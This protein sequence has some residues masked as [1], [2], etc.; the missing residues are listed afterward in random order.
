MRS[1]CLQD[2]ERIRAALKRREELLRNKD[3]PRQSELYKSLGNS[4]GSVVI[5]NMTL[6]SKEVM[7]VTDPLKGPSDNLWLPPSNRIKKKLC[8][9]PPSPVEVTKAFCHQGILEIGE[10]F[11]AKVEEHCLERIKKAADEAADFE[12]FECERRLNFVLGCER[13]NH[14]REMANLEEAYRAALFAERNA[15][16]QEYIRGRTEYGAKYRCFCKEIEVKTQNNA[17]QTVQQA[18]G[19]SEGCISN[20]QTKRYEYQNRV[21]KCLWEDFKEHLR[22]QRHAMACSKVTEV[23]HVICAQKLDAQQRIEKVKKL[24]NEELNRIAGSNGYKLI[25]DKYISLLKSIKKFIQL[26]QSDDPE[27]K[28][29]LLEF[30]EEIEEE[31]CTIEFEENL[32]HCCANAKEAI[33]EKTSNDPRLRSP[34][35]I[36]IFS[37]AHGR[38]IFCSCQTTSEE[39]D[40]ELKNKYQVKNMKSKGE[41]YVDWSTIS[42]SDESSI[43]SVKSK[44]LSEDVPI[45]SDIGLAKKIAGMINIEHILIKA[46]DKVILSASGYVP[47]EVLQQK[48]FEY[49]TEQFKD[50]FNQ[51]AIMETIKQATDK[52]RQSFILGATDS[53]E[54]I[55]ARR[56]TKSG[57]AQSESTA[58]EGTV[59]A[60]STS[61]LYSSNSS[62]INRI[63]D[64]FPAGME[65]EEPEGE[66]EIDKSSEVVGRDILRLSEMH[67]PACL[68]SL[69][70][71]DIQQ[72]SNKDKINNRHF[73]ESMIKTPKYM[74]LSTSKVDSNWI[75]RKSP[76]KEW[77]ELLTQA[78]EKSKKEDEESI[79][80]E[81]PASITSLAD[82][83]LAKATIETFRRCIKED[84]H[85]IGKV[86]IR[87]L[88]DLLEKNEEVTRVLYKKPTMKQASTEN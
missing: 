50:T 45:T 12:R 47:I 64:D 42:E 62:C 79:E 26:S 38:H 39:E 14:H 78:Y 85:P 34:A 55:K 31:I 88:I 32:C 71:V 53:L 5:E 17:T 25:K 57:I 6:L 75:Y 76:E 69:E 43:S 2:V 87:S 82:P 74:Q 23:M 61:E 84:F 41:D 4:L 33:R 51:D 52:R 73:W 63:E 9:T 86:R 29:F 36:I 67:R 48:L 19:N 22:I 77:N 60:T 21:M 40:N 81:T 30:Q 70:T 16:H 24:C 13:S 27:F 59:K 20:D 11:E 80:E 10:E 35:G 58:S 8:L 56:S 7:G 37:R 49:V 46:F 54:L 3:V 68:R 15:L 66:E 65:N 18:D 28:R 1:S 44:S 83:Q 72:I